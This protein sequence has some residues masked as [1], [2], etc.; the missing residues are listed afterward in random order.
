MGIKDFRFM[1]SKTLIKKVCKEFKNRG[2]TFPIYELKEFSRMSDNNIDH[3]YSFNDYYVFRDLLLN[4][5]KNRDI[6]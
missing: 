6:F 5:A 3:R 4:E 2:F 1:S